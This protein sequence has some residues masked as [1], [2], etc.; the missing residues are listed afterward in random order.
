MVY[1]SLK[2][3]KQFWIV[4]KPT[5]LS[6]HGTIEEFIFMGNR[7]PKW[8][9]KIGDILFSAEGTIG[10]TYVFCDDVEN[11][12]TNFHGIMISHEDVN[13][14][15]VLGCF[16]GYLREIGILDKISV[17]GQGGSLSLSHWNYLKITDFDD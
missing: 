2:I 11:V 14:S 15:I 8:S 13:E 7:Q 12:T 6:D 16:L 17:G 5:N 10:K 3:N 4:I 9:F 1:S